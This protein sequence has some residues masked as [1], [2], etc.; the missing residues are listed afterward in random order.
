[1]RILPR[2]LFGRLSLML[3]NRDGDGLNAELT[4]PR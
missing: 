2:T 4:L 3:R 1:M